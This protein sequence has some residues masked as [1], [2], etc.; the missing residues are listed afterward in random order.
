MRIKYV[1]YDGDTNAP[2]V[3]LPDSDVPLN[4]SRHEFPLVY[5]GLIEGA[6]ENLDGHS[7]AKRERSR[8]DGG[9][10]RSSRVC[11]RIC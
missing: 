11:S 5:L 8:Q 2:I 9:Q 1:P 10:G 6:Q 7:G 4:S 3:Q